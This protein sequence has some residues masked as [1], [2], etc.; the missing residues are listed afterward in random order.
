MFCRSWHYCD[1]HKI[2]GFKFYLHRYMI[3]INL[4][5]VMDIFYVRYYVGE[6]EGGIANW[7]KGLKT[8]FFL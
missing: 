1:M 5:N 3:I 4:K 7:V 2:D 8:A 6:G